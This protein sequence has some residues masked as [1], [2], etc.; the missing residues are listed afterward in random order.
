MLEPWR[1]D[2]Y[3]IPK[4]RNMQLWLTRS[5]KG[6]IW[7]CRQFNPDLSGHFT[8]L[9][10][11]KFR[12]LEGGA[13]IVFLKHV[14][15]KPLIWRSTLTSLRCPQNA[16]K[17][18]YFCDIVRSRDNI[19]SAKKN[20]SYYIVDPVGRTASDKRLRKNNVEKRKFC[21]TLLLSVD[22][23]KSVI[24]RFQWQKYSLTRL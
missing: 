11:P 15:P 24:T 3:V 23:E 20:T 2:R 7:R 10:T 16:M 1:W 22:G 9:N 13:V 21:T 12:G 6:N 17:V 18:Y 8:D 4:R 5:V 14:V 19:T